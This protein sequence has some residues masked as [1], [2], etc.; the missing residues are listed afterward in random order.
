MEAVTLPAS[1]LDAV[2]AIERLHDRDPEPSGW[3]IATPMFEQ[4][5]VA[6]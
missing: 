1:G 5:E 6:G 2:D 3:R 4:R